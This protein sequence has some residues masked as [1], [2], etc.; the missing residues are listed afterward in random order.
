ML[1]RYPTIRAVCIVTFAAQSARN[2]SV[3]ASCTDTG[4]P[5]LL[6]LTEEEPNMTIHPELEAQILR[7]YHVEKW[8]TGT[9]AAQ[10]G[11]H[12]SR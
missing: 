8:R 11:V 7:Y 6:N 5:P 2:L 1:S 4:F 12:P 10:L 3:E 9:I